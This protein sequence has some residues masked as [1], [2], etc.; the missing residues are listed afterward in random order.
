MARLNRIQHEYVDFIPARLEGGRLY[1]SM[2]YRTATHLCCCGCGMEVVTPLNP[3]K[4]HLSDH[5]ATVSLHPSIGNWSFPC[6]SHYWITSGKVLWASSMS[7]GQIRRVRAGDHRAVE[8]EAQRE[9][10]VDQ[11]RE[12]TTQSVSWVTRFIEWL[13]RLL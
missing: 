12:E 13:R 7:E 3:A 2:K 10:R 4:W 1:I 6:R 11:P 8:V 5:G 9:S